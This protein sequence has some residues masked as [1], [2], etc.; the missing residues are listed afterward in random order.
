MKEKWTFEICPQALVGK[1]SKNQVTTFILRALTRNLKSH[2]SPC[3]FQE[4]QGLEGE[5]MVKQ[6]FP[7][8]HFVNS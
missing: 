7:I 4:E 5:K 2:F 3:R 8:R 6:F 1:K